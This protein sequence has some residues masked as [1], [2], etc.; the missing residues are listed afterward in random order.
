M[1]MQMPYHMRCLKFWTCRPLVRQNFVLKRVIC[2]ARWNQFRSCRARR[3]FSEL[4]LNQETTKWINLAFILSGVL[5]GLL[6]GAWFHKYRIKPTSHTSM[7]VLRNLHSCTIFTVLAF[8]TYN[9]SLF[10]EGV[11]IILVF[12]F[13]IIAGA[14]SL[15]FVGIALSQAVAVGYP[16]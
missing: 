1:T 12:I 14:C 2:C 16:V 5:A 7:R 11:F 13:M 4:G 10:N 6:L 9:P 15:G 8:A 3:N